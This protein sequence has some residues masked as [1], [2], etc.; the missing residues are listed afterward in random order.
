MT[1]YTWTG[2][3]GADWSVPGDWSPASGPPGIADTAIIQ[4]GGTVNV[5]EAE[6]IDVLSLGAGAQ[7]LL[8]ASP[9]TVA[10]TI[11]NSGLII[12]GG[13]LVVA[14]AG[15]TLDGTG[16]ARRLV[17]R[18][19]AVRSSSLARTTATKALVN[20]AETIIGT[21]SIGTGSLGITN[22]AAGVIDAA[23]LNATARRT[24][25]VGGGGLAVANAGLMEATTGALVLQGD[26]NIANTGTIAAA[27]GTVTVSNALISGGTLTSSGGPAKIV[28][29]GGVLDGAVATLVNAGTIDIT[30]ADMLG[31]I[32]NQGSIAGG[33][34]NVT[35]PVF[36]NAHADGRRVGHQPVDQDVSQSF[37]TDSCRWST[38]TTRS[39][40]AG[41]GVSVTNDAAGV[42]SDGTSSGW[43][44]RGQRRHTRKVLP[45]AVLPTTA[46]HRSRRGR[47]PGHQH[48][49]RHA[50]NHHAV[51]LDSGGTGTLEGGMLTGT[52]L[53]RR[54]A[55]R[56]ELRGNPRRDRLCLSRSHAGQ[57]AYVPVSSIDLLGAIAN[58]SAR[59]PRR[60]ISRGRRQRL[61]GT[62]AAG[63]L[64]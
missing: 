5:S 59:W 57:S 25:T 53:F 14:G 24:L 4:S 55:W 23:T 41:F 20:V 38:S 16:N 19:R 15:V 12:A 32:A 62:I 17:Q 29:A 43:A 28:V 63:Q 21:G 37:E 36:G 22:E 6:S 7:L 52:N 64:V 49:R 39:R 18:R 26:I 48:A 3:N 42:I 30:S 60:A 35:V 51:A 50:R 34:G 56:G 61:S 10:G 11:D 1:T 45:V 13:T 2:A 27:G 31:T 44:A 47:L 40:A 46:R 9:F 58:R 8:S 54:G 33:I